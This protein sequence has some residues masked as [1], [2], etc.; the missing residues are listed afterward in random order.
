MDLIVE[1][2]GTARF[3]D[4]VV[5]CATGRAGITRAKREGDGATPAGSFACRLVYWRADRLARP[6]TSLPTAKLAPDAGWCDAPGDPNYNRPVLLPYPASAEALWRDEA[7]Y[8]LI[9]PLGYNDEP[10]RAGLGSAIFLHVAR[11]DFAPTLGCV[12]L[13]RDDLIAFLAVARTGSRVV[14]QG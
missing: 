7:I 11:P 10:V 2:S 1:G 13:G 12:A 8:D 6:A 5:R 14:V 3:G 9:V 4:R